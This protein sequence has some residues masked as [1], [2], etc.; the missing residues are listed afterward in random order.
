MPSKLIFEISGRDVDAL[1]REPAVQELL[2]EAEEDKEATLALASPQEGDV[3]KIKSK[4]MSMPKILMDGV[5]PRAGFEASIS[6]SRSPK[7][8]M[9]EGFERPSMSINEAVPE[10]ISS[11]ETS[12]DQSNNATDANV[13]AE[14]VEG[15]KENNADKEAVDVPTEDT[16]GR[17]TS[18]DTAEVEASKVTKD[19]NPA[20]IELPRSPE[21]DTAAVPSVITPEEQVVKESAES[22]GTKVS[23]PAPQSSPRKQYSADVLLPLLIFSVVKSNP[24]MLISNLRYCRILKITGAHC[25]TNGALTMSDDSV[26]LSL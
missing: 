12:G 5:I 9:D 3:A 19:I 14:H 20:E 24:P 4:R 7:I 13:A 26:L 1:N 15:A 6:G 17:S 8:P 2:A 10:D 11:I 23:L 16:P 25:M 22:S 21:V 18:E